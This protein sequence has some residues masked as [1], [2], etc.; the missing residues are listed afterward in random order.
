[1]ENIKDTYKNNE[2]QM[3]EDIPTEE[4][5]Y[6]LR[7]TRKWKSPVIDKKTNFWFHHLSSKN[8]LAKKLIS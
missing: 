4:I 6:T 5:I 8:H 1:M 2:P 3:Y 7:C